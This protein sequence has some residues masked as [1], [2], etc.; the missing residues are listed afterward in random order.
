MCI[1]AFFMVSVLIGLYIWGIGNIEAC[2]GFLSVVC[3]FA[4]IYSTKMYK[5]Y[6]NLV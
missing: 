6:K 3:L 4:A 1:I 5:E 2:F